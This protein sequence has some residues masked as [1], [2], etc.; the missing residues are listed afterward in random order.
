MRTGIAATLAQTK[1]VAQKFSKLRKEIEN[2]SPEARTQIIADNATDLFLALE[3]LT[4][5]LQIALEALNAIDTSAPIQQHR[6]MMPGAP[7]AV[8][9]SDV[10]NAIVRVAR[11]LRS[12]TRT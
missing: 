7:R 1:G 4:Y 2:A 10:D 11:S 5:N 12:L 8:R 3:A 6:M 9:H